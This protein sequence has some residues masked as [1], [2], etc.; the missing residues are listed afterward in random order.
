MIH[1]S[2]DRSPA[3]AALKALA[4]DAQKQRIASLFDADAERATKYAGNA[5]GLFVD[6]SK[7]L[8][9]DDVLDNLISL[10]RD[11]GLEQ[12]RDDMV[13][14]EKIN[15][16]ETRAV[17]HVALRDTAQGKY[18]VDGED[19]MPLIQ[20]ELVR[21]RDFCDRIHTGSFTG[22]TG[23][24][25]KTVVNI[26]IGGS[27][28]GPVMVTEALAPYHIEG[29]K[30]HFVS[31]VDGAHL[32]STLASI[33]PETTLFVIASK[34]FTTQE[35]MT[36][37][38]S[39]RDWFLDTGAGQ[40][41]IAKHFIALSTNAAAVSKFGID[42]ANM[43]RFWDWVGGRYSLWSVIGM[44]IALQTGFDNFARLLAGAAQMDRHFEIADLRDNLPVL[45][46]LIGIWNRN[47]LDISAHAVLPYDQSLHRLPAYLQQAD[48]ESNGKSVMRDGMA[49]SHA[50]GPVIFG[51]PGTN[52]QHAFYQLI[53]QG[54]DIIS[55]DFIAPAISHHER[56]DH[57][58][59]LL[60]N[61]LAQPE[62]LMLGKS[63]EQVV[64]ELS[65]S[66]RSDAE[67]ENLAPHRKFPGNRPTTAILMQ[68]LTPETLGALI[69]LY[70]HKIFCQG[71]I[72]GINSFD[73]WG[74]ELGKVLA[75]NILTELGDLGETKPACTQ[76]DSST[77]A[78]V[79][80]INQMRKDTR[81]QD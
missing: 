65:A 58:R 77:N 37:A 73:Q 8:I 20:G 67:I 75:G 56:G 50:T 54:T 79:D 78:L 76:H 38:H 17:L 57:H 74:V 49:T 9:T 39:A 71:H 5:A 42:T 3:W 27:D 46:A 34:T 40:A 2:P 53:H 48:M 6:Y 80:R 19:I 41:D 47:F 64:A 10:A 4:E 12:G 72:W 45:L 16:T 33:D 43:F 31:N 55:S 61:F 28:L 52:G 81:P 11:V 30:T 63:L 59:K 7:N 18:H 35:T 62:A 69:A 23:K 25:L 66:G 70:E 36:N 1:A 60:A 24:P 22:H 44:P 32:A 13:A 68:K 26:G 14:G 51:E 15:S 21:M 29:R